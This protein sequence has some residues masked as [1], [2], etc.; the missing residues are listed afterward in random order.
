MPVFVASEI[1]S[2]GL[3]KLFWIAI[4]RSEPELDQISLP[5]LYPTESQVIRSQSR[6]HLGWTVVAE[7]LLDRLPDLCWIVPQSLQ[8]IRVAQ[9]GQEPVADQVCRRLMTADQEDHAGRQELGGA[10]G[11]ALLF[12]DDE[13]ADQILTRLSP[14]MGHGLVKVEAELTNSA[15]GADNAVV[16]D[17]PTNERGEI[18]GPR[19]EAI[20]IGF[21]DTEQLRNDRRGQGDGQIGDHIKR[22]RLRGASEPVIDDHL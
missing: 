8:L 14:P 6:G 3:G 11:I 17:R 16:I 10:Q 20:A 12:S 2:I 21:R 7:Q 9:Q 5:N 13:P 22:A 19:L 1:K 18:V 15:V 4:R